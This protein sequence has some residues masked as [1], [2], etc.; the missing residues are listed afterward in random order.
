MY[1]LPELS[2]GYE[3]L[4]PF[5]DART[6]EIHHGKHHRAYV[7]KLNLALSESPELA[8]LSIED[9]MRRA[10]SLPEAIRLAVRNNGGGHYN[11]S[12][13][14]RCMN[15]PNRVECSEE[16]KASIARSFGDFDEFKKL[17]SQSAMSLF[18]SGWIWLVKSSAGDLSILTTPN[19]DNPLMSD[20]GIPI[21]A[22][23]VWEHAYYLH[24][25][26]RRAEYI[27]SWWSVVDWRY[28]SSLYK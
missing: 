20:S 5:I 23:D 12:L 21:L 14:W 15:S 1:R 26:N 6:M 19:Q 22:L 7:D 25:Q 27:E 4:E 8:I 18:G 24:Y 11:H 3:A 9:L 16:L 10:L 28:V 2:Y 13:F 17:F